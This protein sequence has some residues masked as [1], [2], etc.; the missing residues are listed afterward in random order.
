[1]VEL[2]EE[3]AARDL[4]K[5]ASAMAVGGG[6][7]GKAATAAMQIAREVTGVRERGG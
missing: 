5:V 6:W 2:V 1:L 4:P 7:S 3:T